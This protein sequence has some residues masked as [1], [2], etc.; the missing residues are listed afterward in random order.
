MITIEN[1]TWRNK[2]SDCLF[3]QYEQALTSGDIGRYSLMLD[4][5]GDLRRLPDEIEVLSVIDSWIK[6]YI[7]MPQLPLLAEMNEVQK[8]SLPVRRK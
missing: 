6:V 8:I 5:Q 2:V 4:Y 7:G 1:L 3:E